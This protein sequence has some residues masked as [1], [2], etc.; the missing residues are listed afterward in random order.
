MRKGV[1]NRSQGRT[2]GNEP[3]ADPTKEGLASS[4]PLP[5]PHSRWLTQAN[6][7]PWGWSLT[8][9][10]L[11]FRVYTPPLHKSSYSSQWRLQTTFYTAKKKVRSELDLL[12]R[13]WKATESGHI[14]AEAQLCIPSRCKPRSWFISSRW[15]TVQANKGR[16][17]KWEEESKTRFTSSN[18]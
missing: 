15:D 10:A 4:P 2:G 12:V 3:T 18:E 7:G 8:T 9:C 1:T 11:H 17:S 14:R 16:E 6:R 13:K 5:T